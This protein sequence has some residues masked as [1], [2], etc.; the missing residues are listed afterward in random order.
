MRLDKFLKV[1]RVF[2]KRTASKQMALEKRIEVNGKIS[3]PSTTIK[4]GDIL[5]IYFGN[6]SLSIRV[7]NLA[8]QVSKKDA[9]LLYEIIEEKLLEH[10]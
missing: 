3:K 10:E 4:V 5:T 7:L 8:K 9:V 2:K 6:K 1:A